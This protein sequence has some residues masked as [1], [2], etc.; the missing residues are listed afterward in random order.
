MRRVSSLVGVAAAVI[1]T[2]CLAAPD[3]AKAAPCGTTTLDNWLGSGF[4]CTVG[5]LTFSNF[6]YSPDGLIGTNPASVVGVQGVNPDPVTGLPGLLFNS[7]WTNTNPAGGARD[8]VFIN[9]NVSGPSI[10][11]FSLALDGV[12]GP[13]LDVATLTFPGGSA[14]TLSSSNN[15]TNS[16][17][18]AAVQSLSVQDDIGIFPGGTVTSVHKDFVPGPIVGAGLPG[19]V[20]ACGGLLALARRRRRQPA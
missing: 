20:A 11:G 15:N 12:V 13:V 14:I 6:V 7:N 3:M 16:I 4:S 18:F 10:T 2:S 8:D 5:S 9:F 1:T 17:S 19:L